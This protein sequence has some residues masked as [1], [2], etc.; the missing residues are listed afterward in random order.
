MCVRLG[1]TYREGRG[2]A[3]DP[4]RAAPLYARARS[5]FV[6]PCGQGELARCIALGDLLR[7]GLG[8][9]PN[10][11]HAIEQ[12]R[13]VTASLPRCE[14]AAARFPSGRSL[15]QLALTEMALERWTAAATHLTAA[16]ADRVHPWMQQNRASVEDALRTARTHVGSLEV[17]TNVADATVA[18]PGGAPVPASSPWFSLPGRVVVTLRAP[19]GRSL[20]RDIALTAGQVTR[21]RM[22]FPVTATTVTSNTTTAPLRLPPPPDRP[23]PS[24]TAA[25]TSTRRVLAWTVAST[26][27]PDAAAPASAAPIAPVATPPVVTAATPPATAPVTTHPANRRVRACGIRQTRATVPDLPP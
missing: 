27:R 9:P 11:A 24:P 20:T 12:Y 10:P 18:L 21:E 17:A 14:E 23:L 8:G 1:D 2:V 26:A 25:G 3:A 19:A 16:L 15:T 4:E 22:E 6:E 13:R 5:A 7:D